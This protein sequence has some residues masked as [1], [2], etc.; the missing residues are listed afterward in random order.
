MPAEQSE[1]PVRKRVPDRSVF[2]LPVIGFVF[3]AGLAAHGM[4][5][6]LV[7]YPARYAATALFGFLVGVTE[8]ISR[9][10]DKPTA[11]LGTWPGVIYIATNVIASVSALWVLQRQGVTFDFGGILPPELAQ[12]LLAGFGAMLLFRSALFVV[13]VGDSD[14]SIGP[15]AVLQIILN[16]ADRACDRLRAGPRSARVYQI[17]RGISFERAKLALPLH[18]FSLMQN[19]S[20]A[21]QTQLMQ[22]IDALAAKAMTDEVK[23]YNLGLLL[24]NVL[25]EDVLEKAVE[26]LKPLILGPPSDEPPILAQASTLSAEDAMAL[27]DICVALDPLTRIDQT[28]EQMRTALLAATAKIKQTPIKNIVVLTKLRERFGATTVSR[29]LALLSAR[30]SV[31]KPVSGPLRSTDLDPPKTV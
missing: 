7:S 12:V 13:R 14:V 26:V 22:T 11:P 31:G 17:M 15:A 28:A 30:Q 18:C 23:A 9:Y 2:W 19:V 27:V 20:T 5:G 3:I 8:L 29:A 4:V 10:R 24:M 1:S 21:E 16:A 25:G 6:N